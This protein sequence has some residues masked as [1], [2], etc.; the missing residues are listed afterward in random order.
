MDY[1]QYI[2]S[3]SQTARTFR[4][5]MWRDR[6]YQVISEPNYRI[7]DVVPDSVMEA[8]YERLFR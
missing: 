4:Y 1:S 6:R 3:S 7:Q 2:P 5:K 8:F